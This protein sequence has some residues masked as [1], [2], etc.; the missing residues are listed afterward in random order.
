MTGQKP[1]S[2]KIFSGSLLWTLAAVAGFTVAN[3]YYNQALLNRIGADLNVSEFRVNLIPVFS[4]IGYAAG[5]FFIVP[6][7]DLIRRRTILTA[8]LLVLSAVL[9]GMASAR[10]IHIVWG[11]SL[12]VG[13]CSIVPQLFIPMVAQYSEPEKK[14]GNVGIIL[15]GLL[16]GILASRVV[17]GIVGEYWGWR[18]I[19]YA[20]SAAMLACL[21]V[22]RRI[23]PDLPTNFKGSYPDLMQSLV[24]LVRRN[25]TLRLVSLRAGLC[26]GSFL[27]LWS[28]LVFK[29][30]GAPFHAGN[31]IIGLLGL[32]GAVGALAASTIGRWIDHWGVR[33][34]NYIGCT[35]LFAA[36]SIFWF[37]RDSY[38]G[39]ISGIILLDIGMQCVQ[40]SN[41]TC[42]LAL[43][44]EASGRINTVFMTTYFLGGSLGTLLAGIFW[45]RFG[46]AGTVGAGLLLVAA[47]FSLV[48]ITKR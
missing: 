16:T 47:A 33:R 9:A 4:Q 28:S 48:A 40:L 22:T 11:L 27:A 24:T 13:S 34:F 46:W 38:A 23:L 44:P 25:G 1:S 43:E 20:A 12:L 7:G 8:D 45:S 2:E 14:A 19:Y 35:V 15:S 3:I 21:F 32:C 30:S 36:W 37:F 41:Q 42:A 10:E 5:L 17:S 26:F 39:I 29:M 31:D 18:T 6:L